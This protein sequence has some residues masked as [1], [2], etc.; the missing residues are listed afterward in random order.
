MLAIDRITAM[1]QVI[2]PATF[3]TYAFRDIGVGAT[4]TESGFTDITGSDKRKVHVKK[5]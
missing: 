1:V 5:C 2:G 4:I 3:T